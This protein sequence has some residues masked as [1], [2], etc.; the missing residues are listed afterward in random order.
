MLDWISKKRRDKKRRE[1]HEMALKKSLAEKASK[2]EGRNMKPQ[3]GFTE[4]EIGGETLRVTVEQITLTDL[5]TDNS[6]FT[7]C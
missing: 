2:Y 5:W 7:S 3:K 6:E 1:A 4:I